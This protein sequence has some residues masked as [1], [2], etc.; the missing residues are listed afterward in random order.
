[1][2]HLNGPTCGQNRKM[3]WHYPRTD[4]PCFSNRALAK[5]VFWGSKMPSKIV[6]WG[7][8]NWLDKTPITKALLPPSKTMEE[9]LPLTK[10]MWEIMLH[11]D[12]PIFAVLCWFWCP[13]FSEDLLGAHEGW[14]HSRKGVFLPSKCLLERSLLEPLPRTLLRTPPRS[15]TNWRTPSKNP[16]KSFWA[17]YP[18]NFR[19]DI[20][21]GCPGG[22]PDPKTFT[23][24][25][26]AQENKVFCADVHDP[27]ALTSMTRGGSQKNFAQENFGLIFRSLPSLSKSLH[28]WNYYFRII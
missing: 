26:R 9:T 12:R 6:F 25:L 2:L 21:G 4:K 20:S 18:V 19:A 24:S 11:L 7:L 1:M 17:G 5:A 22:R 14:S 27:K 28:A 10:K 13:P 16:R 3:M 8:K 23:P 15:N